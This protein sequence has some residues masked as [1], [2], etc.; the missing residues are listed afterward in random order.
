MPASLLEAGKIE[1]LAAAIFKASRH[2]P[3]QFH[4]NKGLAGAPAGELER[5][6]DT[7]MNPVVLDAFALVIIAGGEGPGY[8]GI[9]GH[10]PKVANARADRAAIGKSMAEMREL[11]P[12]PGSYVSESNYFEP[13]WQRAF[14]GSNYKRLLAVK[15]RY[16]PEGLFFVRHGVGTEGWSD[17]GFHRLDG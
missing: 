10:E 15:R 2:W 13:H 7:V 5:A 4:F 12:N 14:W 16:D 3:L 9:K 1:E 8:P 6:K 11:V 17:D